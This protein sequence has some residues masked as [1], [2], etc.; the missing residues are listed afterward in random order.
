[1]NAETYVHAV[2]DDLANVA[3]VGDEAT[4]RAAESLTRAIEPSLQRRFQE[5]LVEA[6]LELSAQLGRGRVEVR[7][8]GD[9]LDLVY[10]EDAG[11]QSAETGDEALSARITLRLPDA[12]KTRVE[13]AAAARGVSVNTWLV[14]P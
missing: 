11:S 6:A 10:V 2:R 1:M 3:A 14:R 5:A 13:T 12:L 9:E 4:A 8:A 7:V